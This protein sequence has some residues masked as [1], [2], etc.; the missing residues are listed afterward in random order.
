VLVDTFGA[1]SD[2]ELETALGP[3]ATSALHAAL[4]DRARRWA[5][6]TAPNSAF[7]ATT[8]GAAAVAVHGHE[9]PVL[10]AAPDVPALSADHARAAL[11]DMEAGCVVSIAPGNDGRPFLVAL[12]DASDASFALVPDRFETLPQ[13]AVES[14]GLLGLLRSERRLGSLA[15][16]RALLADPQ[17]PAD[18]VALLAAL[19]S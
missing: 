4:R 19:R 12:P 18:L 9:G 3:E 13:A 5:H 10:L 1:E 17:A 2:A 14:G 15:D 16:A 6:A 7:E 8:L 11:T